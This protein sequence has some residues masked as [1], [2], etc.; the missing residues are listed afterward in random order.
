MPRMQHTG[1]EAL[2]QAKGILGSE[3]AVAAAV[4]VKQPSV[5]HILNN[6]K[7]VPAEWCIPL[8][9]ATDGKI[10]RHDLRPD[11]YPLDDDSPASTKLQP[12]AAP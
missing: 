12:G 1:I 10:T 8:E 2:K 3:A 7:K 4:G 5:N 9:R 11:L 6:G